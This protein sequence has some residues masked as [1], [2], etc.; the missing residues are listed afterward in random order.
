MVSSTPVSALAEQFLVEEVRAP[1]GEARFNVAPT[2]QVYA[3]AAS[4]GVRRLGTFRWGLVPSWADDPSVGSRMINLRAETVSDKPSFRRMLERHRC[5][6][7]V[8]GF[9]EWKSMGKGRKKQ[10]FLVRSRDGRALALAGLWEVWK[11][12]QDQDADWLRTC[13]IVTTEPND[14]LAPV[15]DRM[16]VVLPPSAWD[17]WLDESVTDV[18]V[19]A[20]LLVPCPSELLEMW[21]VST[22]VNRVENDGPE[23]ALPLAGHEP[24]T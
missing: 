21:P 16:P 18:D 8:D 13:T 9:Y 12:R 15:H 5:I 10:P 20:G 6:V 1:E 3:V 17:T 4:K 23:L 22:D 11:D 14:L 7:P 19:L 24:P 2:D